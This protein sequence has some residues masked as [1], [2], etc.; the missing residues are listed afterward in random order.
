MVQVIYLYSKFDEYNKG[1][2]PA[3]ELYEKF[4]TYSDL[5]LVSFRVRERAKRFNL[6]PKDALVDPQSALII[7][8]IDDIMAS[9]IRRSDKNNIYEFELKRI[10]GSVNLQHINNAILNQCLRGMDDSKVPL[11]DWECAVVKSVTESLRFYESAFAYVTSKSSNLTLS[12]T[13]FVNVD[14]TLA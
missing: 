12:N 8:K 11:Y 4:N 13:V 7:L 14:P 2:M 1:R 5:P 3:Y 10:L 6:L 9:V